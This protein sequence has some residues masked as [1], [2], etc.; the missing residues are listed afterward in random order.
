MTPAWRQEGPKRGTVSTIAV[1]PYSMKTRMAMWK[2]IKTELTFCAVK[3]RLKLTASSA[4]AIQPVGGMTDTN[5]RS[6]ICSTLTC[7]REDNQTALPMMIN[8]IG[9]TWE[10][11]HFFIQVF[12]SSRA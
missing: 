5:P 11:C 8:I 2:K 3:T 10:G 1:I 4:S 9:R 12:T 6:F 7:D